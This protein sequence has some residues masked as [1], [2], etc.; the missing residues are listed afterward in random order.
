MGIPSY[1]SHI[2]RRHRNIIKKYD[3][4]AIEIDNLYLDSNSIIYDS[5]STITYKNDKEFENTLLKNI[6]LKIENYINIIRPKQ[7]IYIA[8]DGVAPVAKLSQQ[9]NRRYKSW[10]QNTVT[11]DIHNLDNV[12]RWDTASITPGTNFM[13]SLNKTMRSH[14]SDSKKFNLEQIIVS[15]SDVF[16]EGEHK[17]YEY[18]RTNPEYHKD[19]T[20]VIYGLDADLIMLTLNHLKYCN[21]M[22]LFRETPHFISHIDNTLLPNQNYMLDIPEFADMLV[23]EMTQNDQDSN[24][25]ISKE[26]QANIIQDYIFMCFF[27]GNDF[28]PHFPA[29]NIRTNGINHLI[30]AYNTLNG[31][32]FSTK[33][34]NNNA[35]SQYI[36]KNNLINNNIIVWKN[37][38][39]FLELLAE[40]EH[41]NILDEYKI[42]EKMAKR[43][44]PTHTPKQEEDKFISIPIYQ[45]GIEKYINPRED[46][47]EY[48][49][50]KSLFNTE[51]NDENS[52]AK[53]EKLRQISVNYLETLE[54]TFKYYNEGCIDW[55][56]Y[57]KYNYPP[58]IKDLVQYVPHFDTNFLEVKPKEPINEYIQLCYV[59]PRLSLNLLP[60]KL[61]N[62]LIEQYSDYYRLDYKFQW[63]YCK[64]FWESHVL[65]PHINLEI[66]EKIVKQYLSKTNI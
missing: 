10:F 23:Y 24:I 42:K 46:Y 48:R 17:I 51:I 58:L 40:T 16:G 43:Y 36:P 49:Y 31:I 5:L 11:Q 29:L 12:K 1:F 33:N 64:Y 38:R 4:N 32:D 27:L 52:N 47:W 61:F 53:I 9:K 14:F 22:F 54:W 20:T 45:R 59:L 34:P 6:C 15:G 28:M 63:A 62:I 44:M 37:V 18:I 19:S 26:Q 2:V 41:T 21:N 56:H 65:M 8:F 50:Y 25:K 30:N 57:Y 7:R 3:S 55:R 66:L 39:K 13:N 35:S 60:E